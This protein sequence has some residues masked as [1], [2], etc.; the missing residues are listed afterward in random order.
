VERRLE[1]SNPRWHLGAA[2]RASECTM[3]LGHGGLRWRRKET[4]WVPRW[5]DC[6]SIENTAQ[7]SDHQRLGGK[8]PG[9][10]TGYGSS[11]GFTKARIRNKAKRE[12][13]AK[14]RLLEQLTRCLFSLYSTP[15]CM[16]SLIKGIFAVYFGYCTMMM[17]DGV[18]AMQQPTQPWTAVALD[19]I[20][21]SNIGDS[22]NK[23]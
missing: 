4:S 19:L 12:L 23:L 18:Y 20:F 8:K 2:D 14:Q 5:G 7:G 15:K 11:S 17:T 1:S 16:I 13:T 6:S 3:A 10:R 9:S 21:S 22:R